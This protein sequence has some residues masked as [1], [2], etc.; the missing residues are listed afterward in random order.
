VNAY[1]RSPESQRICSILRQIDPSEHCDWGNTFPAVS[2]RVRDCT[3]ALQSDMPEVLSAFKT[4]YIWQD[5]TP[6]DAA[7][8]VCVR[9]HVTSDT[10]FMIISPYHL[11]LAKSSGQFKIYF[12]LI[13]LQNL[14]ILAGSLGDYEIGPDSITMAQFLTET[15]LLQTIAIHISELQLVHAS[16]VARNNRALLFSGA[17]GSAKTTLAMAL[18]KQNDFYFLNDDITAIERTTR[19]V[20]AFPRKPRIRSSTWD[21]LS[22]YDYRDIPS[23]QHRALHTDGIMAQSLFILTGFG[24]EPHLQAV[25]AETALWRMTRQLIVRPETQTS[26]LL[27]DAGRLLA[28]LDCYFL[29]IGNLRDTVRIVEEVANETG[30]SPES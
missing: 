27:L 17:S 25:S 12:G 1:I 9:R 19:Q 20:F 23:P 2:L 4:H 26:K 8:T 13:S 7:F 22:K 16:S 21:L 6:D 11:V 29:T 3:V 14:Q 18:C 30:G 10:D 15:I 28:P 24:A 5:S